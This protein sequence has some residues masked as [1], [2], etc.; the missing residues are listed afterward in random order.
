[1]SGHSYAGRGAL[2]T[3]LFFE[4]AVGCLLR[5]ALSGHL[6]FKP[7]NLVFEQADPLGKFAHRQKRQ[8]LPDFVNDLLLWQFV[9]IDRGHERRPFLP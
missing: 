4:E 8:F 5:G 2:T 7:R 3:L 6:S 9:R 1:M